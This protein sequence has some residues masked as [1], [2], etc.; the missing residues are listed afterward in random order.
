M[1][2]FHFG[3]IS[4]YISEEDLD[5]MKNNTKTLY[6]S[7]HAYDPQDVL[8]NLT[9]A[10]QDNKK[11]YYHIASNNILT[12]F[13]HLYTKFFT[14]SNVILIKTNTVQKAV[15]R[16]NQNDNVYIYILPRKKRLGNGVYNIHKLTNCKL[17]FVRIK[18]MPDTIIHKIKGK[19][20]M[21]KP[22]FK[23]ELEEIE[24]LPDKDDLKKKLYNFPF[25]YNIKK[26]L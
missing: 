9:I 10:K 2:K 22:K 14:N 6:I 19:S 13:C 3:T 17:F 15:D 18:P 20:I 4:Y 7:T 26:Y 1:K 25:D 21:F 23:V 12:K 11:K 16:L 24:T 5:K 8:A